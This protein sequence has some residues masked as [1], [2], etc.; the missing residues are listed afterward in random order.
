MYVVDELVKP[1]HDVKPDGDEAENYENHDLTVLSYRRF[2]VEEVG[3]Q[4]SD[5]L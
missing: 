1:V 4:N 5:V 3:F 2:F